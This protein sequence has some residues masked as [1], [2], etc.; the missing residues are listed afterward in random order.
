MSAPERR[1]SDAS[2]AMRRVGRRAPAWV[3]GL[4]TA[5]AALAALFVASVA[6]ARG[7][8]AVLLLAGLAVSLALYAIVRAAVGVR[9]S[10]AV[11]LSDAQAAVA[12]HGER[13]RILHEID[14]A[15]A[16]E[17]PT[18]AIAAAVLPPLR[19][20]L[21]VARVVVNM[22][23]LAAG[24]VEWLAAAGRRRTHVGPGVRYSIRL[25]GDVE[26]LKRGEPQVVDTRALP[27]GREVEAL[28]ASG[29]E[30]YMAVPMIAGGELIGALSFG[31]ERG[32]TFPAEQVRVAREVATQLAIAIAQARLL[33]QVR[34][35]AQEL[36]ER[37]QARTRELEAANEDLQSFAYSV[38]HDLRAPL[39]HIDGFSRMLEQDH[40][41]RLDDD[42]RRLL[43]TVRKGAARM[44]R[45]LDDLLAF[46]RYG[47]AAI[48]PGAVD[49]T[50]LA[51]TV[52]DELARGTPCTVVI[53]TLP[54]ARADAA[55][56]RQVW[57][58]LIGN[59][60]KY[61]GK[62]AEPRVEITGRVEGDLAVYGVRD[63]GAGFDARYADKLFKVFQRLHNEDEFSGT[64]VGLA[65]VHRIVARH[66]GRVWAEGRPGEGATFWFALPPAG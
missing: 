45:L 44:G 14:R 56:V 42:G 62:R 49:M 28:L 15:I 50:A 36:E 40:A 6:P 3:L 41:A 29:V 53:D 57:V 21:G 30:T 12:A 20:L 26:A 2:P 24:E 48:S 18:E 65:I 4:S 52:A 5:A 46:S 27:P 7:Y 61:S 8:G 60:I 59:A 38:S 35:H 39:R 51:R 47:R 63:N 11:A 22:F 1:Q 43:S 58:N 10:D 13:L 19:A 33:A 31:G 55:L 17:E 37:V 54:P 34:R 23:D 9:A 66:G 32:A 64:G 16:A 25:M